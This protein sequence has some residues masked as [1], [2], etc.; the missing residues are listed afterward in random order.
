MQGP[1]QPV[2]LGGDA[3]AAF[4]TLQ[5]RDNYPDGSRTG[6]VERLDWAFAA[7]GWLFC[8]QWAVGVLVFPACKERLFGYFPVLAGLL[9]GLAICRPRVRRVLTEALEHLSDR[10]FLLAVTLLALAVRVISVAVFPIEPMNDHRYFHQYALNL[11]GGKGYGGVPWP[12]LPYLN[13]DG[14]PKAFYPPGMSLLLCAWYWLT[15]PTALAGKFLN[16]LFGTAMVLF[17]YDIG[18]RAVSRAVGRW[19]AL[20]TAIFPTLVFYCATLGYEIVLGTIWCA[21]VDLALVTRGKPR[22]WHAAAM[23]LLLGFGSLLKPICLLMP[24][25]LVVWWWLNGTGWKSLLYGATAV[26]GLATVIAPGLSGIIGSLRG[27]C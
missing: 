23:G 1:T 10:H 2:N 15:A 24:A 17:V 12:Y 3:N 25:L 21:I 26:L 14:G 7:F 19:A 13:A 16:V 27:L 20:L 8:L 5:D 11:L 22:Y 18:R 6:L 9:V 4:H